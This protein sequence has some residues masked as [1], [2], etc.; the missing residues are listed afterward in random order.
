VAGLYFHIPYCRQACHYCDF[1]FSTNLKTLPEMARAMVQEMEI[2]AR[3]WRHP[4]LKSVYFGGG[5][6]SLL[7][8]ADLE[9]LLTYARKRF[10]VEDTAEITL[11]VNPDDVTPELCQTWKSMGINRLSIGLQSGRDERLRWMNRVHNRDQAVE[12]VYVAR[13]A[14]FNNISV[15]LMYQFPGD[16]VAD[17]EPDVAWILGLKPDH[18]SAYG[19][20]LEPRTRFGKQLE[21][22][23]LSPMPEPLA[24]EQFFFIRNRLQEAGFAAYEV[25]N[26]ARPGFEAVHNSAYWFQ[27]P[28]LG[29]GPGAVGLDGRR[30]SLNHPSNPAYIRSLAEKSQ[31]AEDTETLTDR[32]LANEMLL[33]RLRT[34]LGLDTAEL[35]AETGY[36][37]LSEKKEK[38]QN[39]M[40]QGLIRLE[41]RHLILEPAGLVVADR[42][43]LDLMMETI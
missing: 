15:D 10:A 33:T 24:V 1:H 39:W 6:P 32:D 12:S 11:E 25:S 36:P 42:L 17:A 28:F 3:T 7:P 14:G 9:I 22:G 43:I 38:L 20:T 30:R 31:P 35:L 41:D 21:K 29:I 34:R 37:V 2:R 26:F 13:Q 40:Q 5:T 19:L 18:I 8:A 27:K 23:E 16:A 4:S